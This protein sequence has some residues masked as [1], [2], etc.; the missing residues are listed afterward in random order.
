[1]SLSVPSICNN[2]CG[3]S[4]QNFVQDET[5]QLLNARRLYYARARLFASQPRWILT[6]ALPVTCR[7]GLPG[8]Y[9]RESRREPAYRIR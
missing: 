2:K 9:A 3:I 7:T 5:P 4:V 1:M 6:N 8:I